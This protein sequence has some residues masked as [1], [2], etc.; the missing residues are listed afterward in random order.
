ME[1]KVSQLCAFLLCSQGSCDMDYP[2]PFKTSNISHL[3]FLSL[4]TTKLNLSISS[5]IFSRC[6][7]GGDD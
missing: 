1:N 5:K 3:A 2:F 4:I 6:F 7:M